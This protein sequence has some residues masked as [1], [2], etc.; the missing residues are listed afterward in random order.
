MIRT[1]AP[2]ASWILQRQ[3]TEMKEAAV[4]AM[5]HVGELADL[6]PFRG[7][8]ESILERFG[9]AWIAPGRP[10]PPFW[11][12]KA[13]FFRG[14]LLCP[15]MHRA[16]APHMQKTMVFTKDPRRLANLAFFSK[17]NLLQRVGY[18]IARKWL[19]EL[20]EPRSAQRTR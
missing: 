6:F 4:T 18:K 2:F 16:P 15:R 13:V 12:S 10:G 8:P 9:V 1:S 14:A 20:S 17:I 7:A 11:T 5:R 3:L 19:P